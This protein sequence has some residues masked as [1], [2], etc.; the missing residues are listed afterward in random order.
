MQRLFITAAIQTICILFAVTSCFAATLPPILRKE[1]RF[2]PQAFRH[3]VVVSD[4]ALANQVGVDILKRGGNAVD[5]AVAVGF[6]LAVTLPRAGNLG[7]G[8]FMLIWNNQQ[9]RATA[10]DYREKAPLAANANMF[11]DADGKVD[12]DKLHFSYLGVGVP[13]TVAGLLTAQKKFGKLKLL[14]VMQPAILLAKKG[15]KIHPYMAWSLSEAA[16]RLEKDPSTKAIFFKD[17]KILGVG[18]TLKQEDLARSLTAIA[19]N[20]RKAFYQRTIAKQIV[21]DSKRRGGLLTMKDFSEY[22]ANV[23]KPVVGHIHGYKIISMPPPSSGGVTLIELLNILNEFPLNK[24]GHN[25]AK[26]LHVMVEAMNFAYNDRNHYLGDPAFVKMPLKR[27]MSPDYGKQIASRI[28]LEKHTPAQAISNVKKIPTESHQTTH[29]IVIDKDGNVVSNTTTLNFSFGG[30]LMAPKTG[31]LLNNEMAD[32]TA[33]VGVPNVFGLIQ[34]KANAIAPA[35]RPLSSMTPVIVLNDK[36]EPVLTTGSPGGS[37]II[38]TVLQVILNDLVYHL[39]IAS[40]VNAPRVHSQLWPDKMFVEQGVSPDTIALLQKMGHT[41]QKTTAMGNAN[42]AAIHDG[43]R[44]A[45]PDP[46]RES[47]A[48]GY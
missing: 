14:T 13:G 39:N 12:M 7:G 42:S 31:I 16:Q 40:S 33:K 22:K 32:F 30:G 18:D 15:F 45:A 37:R 46:R 1:Q 44:L 8:G 43:W 21:A 3:G 48:A 6:A 24:L 34:G 10:I 2:Q 36:N 41:V 47:H 9:K 17:G 27:L 29:F 19:L 35:K 5:A 25:S 20:G 23:V 26:A 11:V 4:S 28:K 38:T